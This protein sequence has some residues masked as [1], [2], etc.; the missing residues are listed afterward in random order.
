ML[1]SGGVRDTETG[2]GMGMAWHIL[3]LIPSGTIPIASPRPNRLRSEARDALTPHNGA[4]NWRRPG[5]VVTASATA[6]T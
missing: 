3:P 6:V 4:A 1:S 2:M 5:V